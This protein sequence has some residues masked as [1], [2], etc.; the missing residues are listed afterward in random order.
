MVLNNTNKNNFIYLEVFASVFTVSTYF[1]DNPRN[2]LNLNL[3]WAGLSV[4]SNIEFLS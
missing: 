2:W 3:H 1:S 4:F